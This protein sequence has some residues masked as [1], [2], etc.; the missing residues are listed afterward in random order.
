MD[1]EKGQTEKSPVQQSSGGEIETLRQK[2]KLAK[3]ENRLAVE[4]AGSGAEDIETACLVAKERM[5]LTGSVDVKD[6]VRA[7]KQDKPFLFK[8]STHAT[9]RT[10]PVKADQ[11]Q[12]NRLEAAAQKASKN[13][14]RQNVFE[15]MKAR[16]GWEVEVK[17]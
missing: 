14:T 4:L 3:L 8:T 10:Q 13:A 9:D 2:L 5:K 11:R 17:R 12:K 6:I 7:I 15:Y 16:R 1:K